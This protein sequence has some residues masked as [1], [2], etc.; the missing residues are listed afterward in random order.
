MV[1]RFIYSQLLN[2]TKDLK[3][4]IFSNEIIIRESSKSI[5]RVTEIKDG[6]TLI[7]IGSDFV[8]IANEYK[9]KYYDNLFSDE[10]ISFLRQ[11]FHLENDLEPWEY[12]YGLNRLE[13]LN[14][15][16]S[17]VTPKYVSCDELKALKPNTFRKYPFRHPSNQLI[18]F[19]V[20]IDNNLVSLVSGYIGD[21]KVVELTGETLIQHQRQGFA[22]LN[23]FHITRYL[24][25]R[26]YAV[27]TTNACNNNASIHTIESLGFRKLGRRITFVQK[28]EN[29]T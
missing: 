21:S 19:G 2:E 17:L 13:E 10:A 12:L 24:L 28:Q 27:Y 26:N 22:K 20:Y 6:M 1:L 18:Y 29:A 9:Q 23:T 16:Q 5:Y 25:E 3:Y 7:D 15:I 8:S 4:D 14:N 11:Y